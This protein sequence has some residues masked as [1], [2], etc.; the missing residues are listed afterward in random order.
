MSSPA[1]FPVQSF[2]LLQPTTLWRPFAMP[3]RDVQVRKNTRLFTE[4][5]VALLL[6]GH[7]VQFRAQGAS[8]QP[9]L[10]DGDDIIVG[11]VSA[12]DL[13]RGDITMV[14]TQHGLR[15]H[16]VA[17]LASAGIITRGDAGLESDPQSGHILAR[18]V[19]FSRNGREYPLNG[20]RHRVLHA[21]RSAIHKFRAAA[22]CRFRRFAGLFALIA[23][24]VVSF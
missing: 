12:A 18:A 20:W 1:P 23:A 11:P 13:R 15:V 9:N 6:R 10:L 21:I 24:A 19:A 5:S 22:I 14:G 2:V 7:R 4:L 17:H 16:R 3:T 8:M